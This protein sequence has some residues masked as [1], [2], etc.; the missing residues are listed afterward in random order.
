LLQALDCVPEASGSNQAEL[1]WIELGERRRG[2]LFRH[3][4]SSGSSMRAVAETLSG[5]Q[6]LAPRTGHLADWADIV[7]G[8]STV[9]DYNDVICQVLRAGY[10]LLYDFT[11]TE[12]TA[13]DRGDTLFLPGSLVDGG[14]RTPLPTFHW[15]DGAFRRHDRESPLFLPYV[16]TAYEGTRL[17]LAR[18]HRLRNEQ[19][20][21]LRVDHHSALCLRNERQVRE[22][23]LTLVHA[24]GDDDRLLGQVLDRVVHRAGHLERAPVRK[25]G[26]GFR[27]GDRYYPTAES[28]VDASLLSARAAQTDDDLGQFLRDAPTTVPLASV[29]VVALIHAFLRTHLVDPDGRS[30]EPIDVHVHW[31]ALAMAGYPPKRRGYFAK[32]ANSVRWMYDAVVRELPWTRPVVFVMA[33]AAPYLLWVP[34]DRQRDRELLALLLRRV[35]TAIEPW[36]NRMDRCSPVVQQVVEQWAEGEGGAV[37]TALRRQFGWTDRT[38]PTGAELPAVPLVEPAGF[39]ELTMAQACLVAGAVLKVLGGEQP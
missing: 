19:S 14:I 32:R 21:P 7:S 6:V 4:G 16:E 9:L 26:S 5:G 17:P 33:P 13:M 35:R 2:L 25:A 39:S 30:D 28:L 36:P 37:S 22:L 8:R 38:S 29:D 12:T 1:P 3:L 11:Q 15:R 24:A 31:G 23:L 27:S 18:L 10:P 20:V 34:E